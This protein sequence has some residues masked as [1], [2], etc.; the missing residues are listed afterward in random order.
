MSC[1]GLG[2]MQLLAYSDWWKLLQ[3]ISNFP[4]RCISAEKS[5]SHSH[6]GP[7]NQPR[8]VKG[9][10]LN[11]KL[12]DCLIVWMHTFIRAIC[13]LP[14]QLLQQ[15]TNRG[16]FSMYYIVEGKKQIFAILQLTQESFRFPSREMPPSHWT[17][18]A[19]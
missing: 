7:F 4:R 9:V 14:M 5:E 8:W 19:S 17:C 16:F 13:K 10:F 15:W 12:L 18:L 1:G 2:W 3:Y 6:R 11:R